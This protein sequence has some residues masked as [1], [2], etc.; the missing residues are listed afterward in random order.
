MFF[1][2]NH[3]LIVKKAVSKE[4]CSFLFDYFYLK[5]QVAYTMYTENFISPE[6]GFMGT[7]EDEQAPNTYSIYGDITFETLL[8]RLKTLIEK[9]TQLKL[10]PNY[11]YGRIYMKGDVLERHL[12]RFSCEISTTLN[13][14]GDPWSIYINPNPVEEITNSKGIKIDLS[15]GDMLIYKGN[16]LEHWRDEFKGKECAQV[17]LHYNNTKTKSSKENMFDSRPHLGLPSFFKREK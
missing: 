13:L 16:I 6:S 11:A 9:E 7:W 2:K 15:P 14:G 8:A 12:D 10:Y 5:R 3:Y 4:M 17:F 1:N